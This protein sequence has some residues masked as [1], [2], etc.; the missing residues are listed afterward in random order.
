M[1]NLLKTQSYERINKMIPEKEI[2]EK[3]LPFPATIKDFKNIV[4]NTSL[5]CTKI[6]KKNT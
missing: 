4:F 3:L 6:W 5:I 1:F 2:A